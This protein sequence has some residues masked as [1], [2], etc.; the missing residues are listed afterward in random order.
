MAYD[1]TNVF[2]KI[3]RGE[4]PCDRLY[5]DEFVLAFKDINPKA[6]THILVIPKSPY[7]S[8]VDFSIRA[9]A[10]ELGTFLQ[11]VAKLVDQLQL[12]ESGFRL[13]VNSGPDSGEEVPHFHMHLMGGK[14]L[15]SMA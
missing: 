3:L 14:R 10:E 11:T 12:H 9:S 6:P 8:F 13:V 7:S 4:I 1:Q 2:A 15:G 5:E